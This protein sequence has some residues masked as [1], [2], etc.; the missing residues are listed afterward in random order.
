M[1]RFAALMLTLCLLLT[2]ACALA[3]YDKHVTFTINST[4]SNS[5]MDYNSDNMYKFISEKFNFDYEVWPV[6]KDAQSEKIRTWINGGTMPDTL[7]WR[8]FAYQ[9]YVTYAEQGLLGALPQ[10]WEEKYPNLHYMFNLTGIGKQMYVDGVCYGIPHATFGRFSGMS[11]VVN[12]LSVYY[13]K[14][15]AKKLNI[16]IGE[17]VTLSQLEAYIRACID[18]DM[19]G[20]GNTLGFSSDPEYTTNFFMLQADQAYDKFTRGENGFSWGW[21]QP[22]VPK[23]LKMARDW[24][25]KGLIDPDFYL[26]D[27]ADAINN[28]TSGIAAA[29]YHN[30]A[31]SSYL[32]YRTTFEE[33]TKL[34]GNDC[35]GITVIADESD[36]ARAIQQANYWSCTFFSPNTDAETLDRILTMMDWICSEEGELTVLVGVRGETWDYNE[37]GTVKMLTTPNEKG[38]YPA[39]VDLYNSYNVFRSQGILADDY[40]FI[41]PA[42]DKRIVQQVLGA[43]KVRQTGHIIPLDMDYEFFAGD[44]KANYSLDLVDEATRLIISKD[45]DLDKEWQ[46]YI[47]ANKA[48]WQ[49]V[50]TDLNKAFVK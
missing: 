29:M 43:Y 23:C 45:T 28:F 4:H 6:A 15:W 26:N 37:D 35:I 7:T 2:C 5:T 13:R 41:N 46:T 39:T 8:N 32:G 20:N 38:A 12:H 50:V 3:E 18:N 16:D 48:V 31:I 40:S 44:S 27:S 36:T 9:E 49:P 22:D 24:Y 34:N 11:T 19:A 14:D 30:C 10:G 25:E 1:K 17:T 47:D 42:N 21:A 33:S